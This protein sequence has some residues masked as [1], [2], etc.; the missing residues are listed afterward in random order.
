MI[1]IQVDDKQ[2]LDML[3]ELSRR[4][5]NLQPAMK[6]IG[7][8]IVASTKRRF[9]DSVGPDGTPWVANSPDG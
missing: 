3:A 9:A 6:E 4:M 8:D 7:E 2:V 1:T 5:T